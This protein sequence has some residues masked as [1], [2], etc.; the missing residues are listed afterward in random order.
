MPNRELLQK[1]LLFKGCTKEDFELLEGLFQERSV[2]P[3][4]T[5]FAEK[6]PAE[7][8]YII[9]SGSVRVTIMAGEGEEVGLLLMGPG[10]F[11]GE[12]ALIQESSRAVTARAENAVE[13]LMLTRKDFQALTDL[14]PRIAAKIVLSIARLLA[15]RVKA[16]SNK[17]RDLLLS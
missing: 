11:F 13:V 16:Y 4:A 2:Q 17:L 9:K 14:E 10:E 3:G 5:I 6:M 8:L 7:A 1:N 15:M 12:I